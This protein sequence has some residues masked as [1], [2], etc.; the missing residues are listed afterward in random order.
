M[1]KFTFL[2][3][4]KTSKIFEKIIIIGSDMY[5][6]GQPDLEKAFERLEDHDFVVGP[7]VERAEGLACSGVASE[8]D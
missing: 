1:E 2:F 6:L 4:K 5:D 3:S 7:A 8:F